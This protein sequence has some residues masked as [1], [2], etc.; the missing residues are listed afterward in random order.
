MY[1]SCSK[2]ATRLPLIITYEEK[3]FSP[4]FRPKKVSWSFRSLGLGSL[5]K[6]GDSGSSP[7]VK[8]NNIKDGHLPN[9]FCI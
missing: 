2:M 9:Q 4:F 6:W 8:D 7:R 5:G 3:D 1:S